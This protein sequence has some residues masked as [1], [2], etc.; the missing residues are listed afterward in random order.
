[1]GLSLLAP[2]FLAALAGIAIPVLIHLTRRPR[3]KSIPF[4]SI[5]FLRRVP[6][7]SMKRRKIRHWWLL[8]LRA[9]AIAAIAFAFARPFTASGADDAASRGP[10]ELVVLL[11]GSL[12]MRYGD[13]WS[14]ALAAASDA[15]A[16]LGAEDRGTIVLFS[17]RAAVLAGP[18]GERAALVSSLDGLQPGYG[19]THLGGA[20]GLAAELL[21]EARGRPEVTVISDLQRGALADAEDAWLPAG[22]RVT[23]AGLGEEVPRNIAVPE[24][25]VERL[26]GRDRERIAVSARVVNTGAEPAGEVPVQLEI[27]G[28][29]V[30]TRRVTLGARGAASVRFEDVAAPMSEARIA[31]RAGDDPLAVD[32]VFYALLRPAPP[33]VV[34]V[35]ADEPRRAL[36][37]QRALEVGTDPR[38]TLRVRR[39]RELRAA[40]LDGAGVALLVDP[41][42]A[43]GRAALEA[44][45]DRGGGTLV[46]AG[47]GWPLS[48]P[49][50]VVERVADNGGRLSTAEYDHPVFSVF[51]APRSGD[52]SAARFFRY[53]RAAVGPEWRVLAR[54][55]DG[56]GALLE[57]NDATPR[58][59]IL[60]W[61]SSLDDAWTDFPVQPVFLP[62]V[63]QVVRYLAAYE[64]PRLAARLGQPL[65][66]SRIPGIAA[67]AE[68]VVETPS[69][70]R[71]LWRAGG[72][73]PAPELAEPGYYTV[74]PV[75]AATAAVLAANPVPEES[76]LAQLDPADVERRLTPPEPGA[77]Q[78]RLATLSPAE[79]ERRQGLWWYLLI[80]VLSALLAESLLAN[81]LPISSEVI[82]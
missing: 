67:G 25:A 41:P 7:R 9:A 46:A 75:G 65:D 36:F 1:M 66:V 38:F 74:R 14:R 4:P 62:F 29:R 33:I 28:A 30:A 80:G 72:G 48:A 57:R 55:D 60:W 59:R 35:F 16:G 77:S 69:G 63:H 81:R 56:I 70:R 52:L 27:N 44:F 64:P 45:T 34:A 54:L 61:A 23:I 11:D 73:E 49:A 3:D 15:V 24:L 22:T 40:D 12:S 37:V 53:Q 17:D 43:A 82:R 2:M 10:R 42:T 47:A 76:D 39:A 71:V 20:V 21:A 50:A 6:Y 51:Q 32:N 5:A 79:R 58:G 31:V 19:A 26:P 78:G 68:L 8:A 18:T 13:R